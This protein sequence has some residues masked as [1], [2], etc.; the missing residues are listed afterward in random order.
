MGDITREEL[1]AYTDA[2]N[3]VA[4]VLEKIASRLEEAVSTQKIIVD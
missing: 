3:K 2:Q 4:T 1:A